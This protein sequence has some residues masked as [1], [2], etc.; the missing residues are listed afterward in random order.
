MQ[1]SYGVCGEHALLVAQ[2]FFSARDV[3]RNIGGV[4]TV[5]FDKRLLDQ[6]LKEY[7]VESGQ[8]RIELYG[9]SRGEWVLKK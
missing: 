2:Q 4:P 1:G 9:E 7:L 6:I 3:I 5:S 8:F